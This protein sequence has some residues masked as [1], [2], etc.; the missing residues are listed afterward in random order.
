MQCFR[1][2]GIKLPSKNIKWIRRQLVQT[3]R[4]VSTCASFYI[5]MLYLLQRRTTEQS[6]SPCAG[7]QMVQEGS[8]LIKTAGLW[9]PQITLLFHFLLEISSFTTVL[10]G[11]FRNNSRIQNIPKIKMRQKGHLSNIGLSK[12]SNDLRET[13]WTLSSEKNQK[14]H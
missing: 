3:G 6:F 13:S 4:W 2:R 12:S 11:I 14:R 1:H 7:L 8:G 5:A 10:R 9:V